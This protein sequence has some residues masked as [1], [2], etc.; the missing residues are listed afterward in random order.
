MI[1]APTHWQAIWEIGQIAMRARRADLLAALVSKQGQVVQSGPF[2]GM[3]L[4]PRTSPEDGNLLPR[5]LGCYE[6]ELHDAVGA[7][8]EAKPDMVM[9]IGVA[10]GYYPVGLARLLPDA[11]VHGFERS[12]AAQEL[13]REAARLNGVDQRVSVG[14][15][16]SQM[17]LQHLL[18]R[19]RRPAVLCD[20]EGEERVLIDPSRVPAL[21]GCMLV[22]ECHDHIDASITQVLAE[23]LSATHELSAVQEGARDPNAIGFLQQLDSLDRWLAV[24]EFR[25]R[26]M[27][28]LIGMPKRGG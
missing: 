26:T 22:V 23:R 24:C 1:E 7:V 4:P 17:V 11:H 27:H 20:A 6:S 19:G 16:C 3:A 25:P 9:C 18:V 10:E 5:L 2:A 28:W 21:A 13:C 14:G 15:Q 8:I 12:D